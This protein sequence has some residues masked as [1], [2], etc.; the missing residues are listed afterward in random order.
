MTRVLF[1]GA[2]PDDES[3]CSGTIAKLVE[4]GAR[5]EA[6]T[7][8][9]CADMI[10]EGFTV[11]DLL[12]EW[13]EAMA[14]L[15]VAE[16]S[17]P[18]VPNRRFP[19]YRQEVLMVLDAYRHRNYDLVL[20]P[21]GCD[22]HQDHATISAEAIRVFKNATVLGYELPLNAVRTT[23]L[24]GFIHLEPQ[25]VEAKIRHAATYRSQAARPYMAEAYLRGLVAVRGVQA[26]CAAAEAFEVVRWHG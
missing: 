3:A 25:H 15:G 11:E 1:L 26:G 8:S 10:P 7:F 9:N 16:V 17:M 18:G 2:H 14:G 24:S 21:A 12:V 20:A 13:R 4:Q 19:E 22:A 23:L 6:V 5:V